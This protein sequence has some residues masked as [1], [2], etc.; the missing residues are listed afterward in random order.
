MVRLTLCPIYLHHTQSI[1]HLHSL[2]CLFLSLG[3]LS[4]RVNNVDYGVAFVD[5]RFKKSI[6]RPAVSVFLRYRST[7]IRFRINRIHPH[8]VN[9]NYTSFARIVQDVNTVLQLTEEEKKEEKE[10]K[11]NVDNVDNEEGLNFLDVLKQ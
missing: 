11:E 5:S 3:S 10:E 8:Y 7:Q 6:V 9:S 1:L 4:F 2:L